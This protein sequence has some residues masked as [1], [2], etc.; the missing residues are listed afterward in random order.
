LISSSYNSIIISYSVYTL[1]EKEIP[2]FTHSGFFPAPDSGSVY[3]VLSPTFIIQYGSILLKRSVSLVKFAF[4]GEI[5]KT[6]Y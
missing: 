2:Y 5:I 6:P 1:K 3:Y 4:N